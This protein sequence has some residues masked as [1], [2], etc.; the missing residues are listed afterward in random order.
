MEVSIS[1]PDD[2]ELAS[3]TTDFTV[4]APAQRQQQAQEPPPS[5]DA[6][7]SGLTLSDVTLAFA[8]TT[9]EYTARVAN[10]V[11]E[12]TVTPTTNDDGATYK[13]KLGRVASDA[14][15]VIPLSRREETSSP[16]RSPPRTGTRSRSTP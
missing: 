7:L 16:S 3:A 14:D 1:S 12:T 5:I 10:G 2:V 15:G 4:A 11:D 9:T 6:A 8:S 13:I